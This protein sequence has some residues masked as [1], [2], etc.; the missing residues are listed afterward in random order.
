MTQSAAEKRKRNREYMR[1]KRAKDPAFREYCRQYQRTYAAKRR[2]KPYW[3]K[4]TC[5]ELKRRAQKL[6]VPFDLEP[7]DLVLPD[8]CPIF[9]KPLYYGAGRDYDWSPSVDRIIP[10]LGYIKTNVHVISARANR[11]KN[12]STLEEL[13]LLVYYLEN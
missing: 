4:R 13:K 6:N 12:D 3:P 10:S 5:S 7:A 9:G 2:T 8:V 11:I 1:K